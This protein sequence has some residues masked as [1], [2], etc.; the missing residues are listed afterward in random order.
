[1]AW[2]VLLPTLKLH[3]TTLLS[4]VVDLEDIH[5]LMEGEAGT[6][7]DS[8]Q[9]HLERWA[10]LKSRATSALHYPVQFTE[11]D[12][13]RMAKEYLMAGLQRVLGEDFDHETRSL[14]LKAEEDK[15]VLRQAG[16]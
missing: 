15:I 9:I 8:P 13:P 10:R 7:K 4:I 12:V 11:A 14:T 2:Y 16:F 6:V 3:L 5:A 1:M